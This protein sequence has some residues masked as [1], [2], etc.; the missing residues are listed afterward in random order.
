MKSKQDTRT[1]KIYA[2]SKLQ[3]PYKDL[4]LARRYWIYQWERLPLIPL[5]MMSSS[6]GAAILLANENFSWQKLV[7]ASVITAAYLLQIRFADEPK[8]YEHDNKYY[9]T[10]P[11]QRGAITLSELLVLRN[12]SIATF[13]I[14]AIATK[15][16]YII[17]LAILQ[18]FYSYLTREEFYIRNWLRD[19]FLIY[20]FSHYFQLIILGWLTMSILEVPSQDKPLYLG[21]AILLMAVVELARK[22]QE[23]STDKARDTYSSVLGRNKAITI[24]LLLVLSLTLYS[25]W[26]LTIINAA[27]LTYIFLITGLVT[28]IMS[29][30]RYSRNPDKT[31][32]KILQANSLV[33]Y[34]MNTLAVALGA[35]L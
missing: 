5:L 14:A 17:S 2:E 9:P 19:H 30:Y 16:P 7:I 27:A 21:F 12:I 28:M 8:D 25:G 22:I 13:F 34:F 26:I 15:S 23:K 11:V 20:M 1:T 35:V 29:S 18:Q 3:A 32:T 33:F 6:V 10:R 24:L 31:N 4:S